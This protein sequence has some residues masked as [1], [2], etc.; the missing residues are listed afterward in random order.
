VL[1][2][3]VLPAPARPLLERLLAIAAADP[4]VLGVTAG[5][6]AATGG[7]DGF[8]DLDLVVVCRSCTSTSRSS[9]SPRLAI[10][11]RTVWCSGSATAVAFLNS[12][13]SRSGP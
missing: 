8:S 7:M 6:S 10:A 4:R 11:W 13:A 12:L 9:S 1:P 3:E 5:G 2:F